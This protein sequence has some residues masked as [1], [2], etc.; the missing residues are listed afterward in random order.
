MAYEKH[1]WETG[2]VIT[3]EKLNNIEDGIVEGVE[4]Y[5]VSTQITDLFNYTT[6][7]S[8]GTSITLSDIFINVP[9]LIV[10]FD[11]IEYTLPGKDASGGSGTAFF[12][13]DQLFNDCPVSIYSTTTGGS[14]DFKSAGNH[15]IVGKG[16]K[17][18]VTVTENFVKGVEKAKSSL[19]PDVCI[20]D[21]NNVSAGFSTDK[22]EEIEK[23]NAFQSKKP[24]IG[25]A[26]TANQ[27]FSFAGRR[28]VNSKDAYVFQRIE[29]WPDNNQ[30]S[31]VMVCLYMDGTTS[32]DYISYSIT[33]AN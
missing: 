27:V 14:L 32:S 33:K 19:P 18:I 11:G 6:T 3:A 7:E 15:T 31:A 26:S 1:T 10:T 24:I 13:G 29:M 4:G 16:S 21:L 25:Y 12:Y 8:D 20:I 17:E 23:I 28:R 30:M 5:D 22:S 2:E 9:T